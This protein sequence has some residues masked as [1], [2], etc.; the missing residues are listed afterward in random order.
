MFLK[1]VR[2]QIFLRKQGL[3]QFDELLKVARLAG[4]NEQEFS[5]DFTLAGRSKHFS[6]IVN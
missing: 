6:A 4:L 3:N 5:S 1:R 2:E